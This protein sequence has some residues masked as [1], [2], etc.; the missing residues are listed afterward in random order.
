MRLAVKR[1]QIER[2]RVALHFFTRSIETGEASIQSPAV[3]D[4]GRLSN[5]PEGFFDQWD[6][7][8]EALVD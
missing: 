8:V 1:H 5:W 6:K 3:L 7:D 4:N 2:E